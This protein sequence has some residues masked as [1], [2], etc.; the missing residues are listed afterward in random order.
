MS[1][2]KSLK[3]EQ[4][5]GIDSKNDKGLL[6]TI[7]SPLISLKVAPKSWTFSGVSYTSS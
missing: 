7:K 5:Y 2:K 1:R 4:D 6:K 3:A